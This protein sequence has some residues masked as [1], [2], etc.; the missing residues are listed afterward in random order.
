MAIALILISA[1]V[2]LGNY[3]GLFRKV[4]YEIQNSLNGSV[5]TRIGTYTGELDFGVFRGEGIFLFNSGELYEGSWIDYQMEGH[6]TLK[7]IKEG[8]YTGDFSSSKKSG[9]GKYVWSDGDVYIGQWK[10]DGITGLGYYTFSNGAVL[11][12][13]FDEG[14][15]ISGTFSFDNT[16]GK[17]L[18]KYK[19]GEAYYAD[20]KFSC[21]TVYSG[22]CSNEELS[23]K[24]KMIFSNGDTYYGEYG[25]G[26]R[27]GEGI[28]IWEKGDCYDGEWENDVINGN[29]E[30]IFKNDN[31]LSGKFVNGVFVTGR[32]L[33]ENDDGYYAF[34]LENSKPN[35]LSMRLKSGLEYYG[36]FTNG[37]FNGK[38]TITYESGDTYSGDFFSGK[39]SGSG[40]YT[41]KDGQKYD[42]NWSEDKMNGNG[43][44]YYASGSNGYK[45]TGN[46]A[47]GY[48]DGECYYYVSLSRSYLTLWSKGKCYKVME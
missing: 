40:I 7:N 1:T 29:G 5:T 34:N 19:D 30:Y 43:T 22:G 47:N 44:Y 48:P 23:G 41:W 39:R 28:Y 8:T 31:K 26:K 6:G 10:D 36:E 37:A 9:K 18:V 11:S 4:Y 3:S 42:G 25:N 27:N 46:Y 21:G 12:G 24:G 2:C 14:I 13:M 16:S 38:G 20:I 15:L 45:L 35:R 17:Y 33:I 32:L